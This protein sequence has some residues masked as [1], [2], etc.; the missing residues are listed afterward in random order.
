VPLPDDITE[1]GA[2]LRNWGRWGAEDQVGTLNLIDGAARLRGAACVQAGT[3]F[4]LAI[5][6]STHGPQLGFIPGRDNPTHTMT[7][8]NAAVT[9]AD[10]VCF[11][12]D[13]VAMGLQAA[14][15]WDGL[16]HVSY[17]GHLY[18]GYPATSV[19]DAGAARLGIHH[20][21]ALASRAL[22]LDIPRALGVERLP[23]GHPIGPDDLDAA[24]EHGRVTVEPGDVVLIRTGHI[25]HLHG[26]EPD[27]VAYAITTPGPAIEAAA[28]FHRHDVAAV[29]LDNYAF[30]VFPGQR[31]D[32]FLPVHYLHIVE[33]GL[34]QGQNWDLE[35]LAEDCAADGRH[36]VLL[37]APPEPVV[38]GT[39]APVHPVAL[40]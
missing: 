18:N 31:D 22:V 16:A 14:T 37:V 21:G 40:K 9:D 36:A 32:A 30:E 10:G 4:S 39:G 34:T 7:Q 24:C 35:A 38:G 33:M 6:W 29:A 20:V 12:D 23:D 26:P 3:A 8:V 15:H 11:N 28:W 25:N 5:D 2:K 27:R 19:T 17:G 1:L 13:A